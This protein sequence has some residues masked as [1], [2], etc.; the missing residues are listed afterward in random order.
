MIISIPV[1]LVDSTYLNCSKGLNLLLKSLKEDLL[2][3]GFDPDALRTGNYTIAENYEYKQG[4]R[5]KE[6]YRGQVTIFLQQ[7]YKPDLIDSF[8]QT[9][10]KFRIQYTVRFMLSEAQKLKLTEQAMSMAVED[11]AK[12]AKV[13][14]EAAGVSLDGVAKISYGEQPGRPGPLVQLK[15][16]AVEDAGVKSGG[17]ELFPGEIEVSQSVLMVWK[18]GS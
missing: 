8:L 1:V 3:N 10:E 7:K 15:T 9:A 12:K 4:E 11:A 6:G 13:L 16:M 18:I 14:S 17:L 5:I 2:T